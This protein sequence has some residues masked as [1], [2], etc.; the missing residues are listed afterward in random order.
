MMAPVK[1]EEKTLKAYKIVPASDILDT[2]AE[3]LLPYIITNAALAI[4]KNKIACSETN[5]PVL[6][7]II[8]AWYSLT[9]SHLHTISATHYDDEE[10]KE[11]AHYLNQ[12]SEHAKILKVI[13]QSKINNLNLLG[14]CNIQQIGETLWNI[15]YHSHLGQ[16][17]FKKTAL[18]SL[19][20]ATIHYLSKSNFQ[21]PIIPAKFEK[22]P[23][24]TH[25]ASKTA[26]SHTSWQ[27]D[28]SVDKPTDRITEIITQQAL[29]TLTK[30][31]NLDK[32]K[33][34]LP[35]D[36]FKHY[37]QLIVHSCLTN[38][39]YTVNQ[40]NLKTEDT[41]PYCHLL[42]NLLTTTK[43]VLSET[44]FIVIDRYMQHSLAQRAEPTLI[45]EALCFALMLIPHYTQ[46]LDT[47]LFNVIEGYAYTQLRKQCLEIFLPVA[48]PLA[49]AQQHFKDYL[50]Q[51][52]HSISLTDYPKK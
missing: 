44:S 27:S 36:F 42:G 5:N 15:M 16:I 17:L 12:A 4:A 30:I 26:C 6:R 40:I 9:L 45:K 25:Y 34:R 18:R 22:T 31:Q 46:L 33:Y 10:K 20:Y 32:K 43:D 23:T 52:V 49:Q 1:A 29:S 19:C 51:D 38:S 28:K 13:T 21:T 24:I 48:G 2:K 11:I 37:A 8:D 50:R 14:N 35:Q 3:H 7:V 39:S 47:P 41:S